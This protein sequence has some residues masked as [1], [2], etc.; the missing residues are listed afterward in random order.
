MPGKQP[1][2]SGCWLG[3]PTNTSS[4][5]T[6]HPD[7]QP[8]SCPRVWK[9]PWRHL[10]VICA[11]SNSQV[12]VLSLAEQPAG[13]ALALGNTLVGL[14][15][16]TFLKYQEGPYQVGYFS[17]KGFQSPEATLPDATAFKHSAPDPSCADSLLQFFIYSCRYV[18]L[19]I[20]VYICNY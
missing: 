14:P 11:N 19:N 12:F 1:Q 6:L 10:V 18:F 7:M 15:S 8:W 3:F 13:A 16:S 20:F 2:I 17:L 5:P 9:V 4:T